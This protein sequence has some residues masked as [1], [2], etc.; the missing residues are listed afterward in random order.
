[1][2][3]VL[4]ASLVDRKFA[5]WT[6]DLSSH[7]SR[8]SIFAHIRDIPYSLT[9]P[10]HDIGTASENLLEQGRGSCSPKHYLLAEMFTRLNLDIVFA[11]FAFSWNDPRFNYP[12]SL[13]ILAASLPTAYH[14]ACRVKIGCRWVLVD[15][16]W[17]LP[18]A[19]AGFPVNEH[20]DGLK[21]TKCAVRQFRSPVRTAFC[22]TLKNE[23]CKSPAD[24][25]PETI[26]GEKNHLDVRDRVRYIREK[27]ALDSSR[28]EGQSS[29]FCRE[30]SAWLEDV[31]R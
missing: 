2:E 8:V 7:E 6:K 9:A 13:R 24:I 26:D 21:D 29:R 1:M 11:T 10:M 4:M 15:A 16:T 28:D 3:E 27:I 25:V 19:K 23:P 30:F 5:E 22:R 14:L 17:D 31:R 12:P 20:W 18:L